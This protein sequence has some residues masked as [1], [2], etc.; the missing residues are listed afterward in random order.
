METMVKKEKLT[1]AEIGRL[2]KEQEKLIAEDKMEKPEIVKGFS[3]EGKWAFENGIRLKDYAKL[4][5]FSV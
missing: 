5:G 1:F 4:K 3:P 2:K